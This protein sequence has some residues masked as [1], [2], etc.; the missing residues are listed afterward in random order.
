MEKTT[1]EGIRKWITEEFVNTSWRSQTVAQELTH[2][3]LDVIRAQYDSYDKATKLGVLFSMLYVRKVDLPVL[4]EN[5]IRILQIAS[6]D[7]D[8][9]VR[10]VGNALK[11]F[12]ITNRFN[13]NLQDWNK[14]SDSYSFMMEK[15]T[16]A[17]KTQGFGFHLD[18][19]IMMES[20]NWPSI[21]YVSE[22]YRSNR[23][24]TKKHFT[25]RGPLRKGRLA[26]LLA[27]CD[28]EKREQLVEM[29][30]VSSTTPP[31]TPTTTAFSAA[32]P[33]PTRL[34]SVG[35][36]PGSLPPRKYSTGESMVRPP[37]RPQSNLFINRPPARRPSGPSF[38][39]Q[40][41]PV[42]FNPT[43]PKPPTTPVDVPKGFMRP[44][45]T[46]MIDF[47]DATK[48][49][50]NNVDA[51]DKATQDLQAQQE[52]RR[53]Q[54]M[55]DRKRAL[56]EQRRARQQEREARAAAAAASGPGRAKGRRR[57]SVSSASETAH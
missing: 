50:Q 39:R 6:D 9:W 47:N 14:S 54:Q 22:S 57:S 20:E 16:G 11:D 37:A 15:I 4:R 12:P 53:Q 55:E 27:L 42:R 34:P 45:R 32:L 7:D 10:I 33:S 25:P 30:D 29:A 23:P 56:E 2:D 40:T 38:L 17:I 3:I 18:E 31:V 8:D 36:R 1:P 48:L 26:E 43:Q 44:S 49:Q 5:M 35:A 21:A 46:Q 19:F 13:F 51:I 41:N 28:E 24:T 52:A